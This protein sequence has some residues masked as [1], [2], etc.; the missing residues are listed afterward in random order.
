MFESEKKNEFETA[1]E[2]LI[3]I[4]MSA[5]N[6]PR[7][8]VSALQACGGYADEGATAA[9]YALAHATNAVIEAHRRALADEENAK[10]VLSKLLEREI[11]KEVVRESQK[12]IDAHGCPVA[13]ES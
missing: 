12:A 10:S 13:G 9:S 4:A 11:G 3:E 2:K 7:R 1:L 6:V 5:G 8:S